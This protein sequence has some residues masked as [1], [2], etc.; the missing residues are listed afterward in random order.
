MSIIG[1]VMNPLE[2]SNESQ[3]ITKINRFIYIPDRGLT[4][5]KT[6]MVKCINFNTSLIFTT[7]SNVMT[8]KLQSQLSRP[9]SAD[10]FQAMAS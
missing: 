10:D 5:V 4:P 1:S 7:H 6:V 9:Y 3:S 2:Y 8:I